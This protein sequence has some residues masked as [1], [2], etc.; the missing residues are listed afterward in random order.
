MGNNNGSVG[1]ASG[2]IIVKFYDLTWGSSG[3]NVG[4]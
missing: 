2:Y 3:W 1:P 4:P